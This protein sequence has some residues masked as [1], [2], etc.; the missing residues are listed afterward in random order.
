[1][2]MVSKDLSHPGFLKIVN[3]YLSASFCECDRKK[4][5]A[6]GPSVYQLHAW[7]TLPS[8]LGGRL[9]AERFARSN[10][11]IVLAVTISLALKHAMK[12]AA[13]DAVP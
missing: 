6:C 5:G 11:G 1:M 8:T 3:A 13:T 2:I 10:D 7:R 9:G 4:N 12:T